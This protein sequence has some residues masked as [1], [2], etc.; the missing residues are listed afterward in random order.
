M[1]DIHPIRPNALACSPL[2]R[3]GFRRSDTAWITEQIN[4]PATLFAPVWR[5][6]SLMRASPESA[7][8]AVLLPPAAISHA[9]A[10]CNWAFLGNLEDRPVFAIDLSPLDE[11]FA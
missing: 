10:T 1:H 3:A 8:E 7:A 9:Q 2:D 4:A 5:S 11:P 6:Q